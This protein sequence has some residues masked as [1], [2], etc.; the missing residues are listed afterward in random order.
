MTRMTTQALAASIIA[1][2]VHYPPASMRAQLMQALTTILDRERPVLEGR[3]QKM[4][5][6]D[7][8]AVAIAMGPPRNTSRQRHLPVTLAAQYGVIPT[9]I[10][11]ITRAY[12]AERGHLSKRAK[13]SGAD[14]AAII[15]AMGP[16]RLGGQRPRGLRAKVAQR[17]GC[18]LSAVT[19]VVQDHWSRPAQRSF[20]LSLGGQYEANV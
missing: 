4:T 8:E 16:P 9:Y 14:R 18:S 1:L 13:L 17:Y 7:R 11:A 12:W 10:H 5:A 15:N 6:A 2:A 3:D 19:R 20:G